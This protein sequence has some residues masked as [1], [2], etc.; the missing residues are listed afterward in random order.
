[1][2]QGYAVLK[3]ILT[4]VDKSKTI[5]SSTV[6]CQ[7]PALSVKF[8]PSCRVFTSCSNQAKAGK[9][10]ANN[11]QDIINWY[12][13]KHITSIKAGEILDKYKTTIS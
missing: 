2:L 11:V 3:V 6:G 5:H 12:S 9:S 7:E 10:K 8:S 13:I 4:V 1:M